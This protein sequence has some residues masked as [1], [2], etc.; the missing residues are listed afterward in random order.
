MEKNEKAAKLKVMESL[1]DDAYKGIARIDSETMR[2]LG[3]RPGDVVIIKGGKETVAIVDRAYPADVGEGIIRIDGII[4]RN[5]KTGIGEPV[6]VYRADIKEAKKVIIAPAQQGIIIQG[7]PEILKRGLL[8]RAVMKGDIIVLGG[9]QRRRDLMEDNFTS[10]FDIFGEAFGGFGAPTFSTAKFIIASTNPNQASIIT[11]S[12]ELVL[13]PKAVEVQE[14]KVPD[15]TYEDIGGLDEELKKIREMVELPLKHPEIFIRLGIEPPKGVLLHGPPGTGKTLLAKAVASETEANFI[16]LNGPECMSKFYGE[17]EKRIRDIFEEAEK[18]APAIIFIDEIDAIAPKREESFGEVERRVV[19]QILTMMDGLKS[20]GK[21]VVIGA[22][23][24]PNS[25]DPALRR[26]GRFDREISINVPDK[27]GRLTILKIHTRNMPLT[28]DVDLEALASITHGFVGADIN[29]LC[30]EAAMNVLRKILPGLKLKE[31]EEIPKEI[32]DKLIVTDKDFREAL[33]VVRPSAMREVLV[34]KPN[35]KWEDVGGLERVK[36]ELREA[37]EWPLKHPDAF[38]RLGI[39]PPTGI[40]LYGAPGTGKTLLAK[41]VANESEANFIQ[42]KGPSLLCLSKDT[43]IISTL[44]GLQNIEKF[45][46]ILKEN[47]IVENKENIEYLTPTKEIFVQALKDKEIDFSKVITAYKLNVKEAYKITFED[48]NTIEVS[49]NQP[50]FTFNNNLEWTKTRDL[51]ENDLIGYP[52]RIKPF[53]KKIEIKVLNNKNLIIQENENFNLTRVFSSHN[54]T[55]LPKFMSEELAEFL[56]WFASEGGISKEKCSVKIFNINPENK[57]RIKELFEMF[58]AKD[59]I[60]EIEKGIA[61]YSAPL[62]Y[63]LEELFDMKFEGRKSHSIKVPKLL[64]LGNQRN[65]AAFLRG[66]W[67]GDGHIDKLKAEYGTKSEKLAQGIS[68]LLTF[69][70]IRHKLWARKDSMFIITISGKEDLIKFDNFVFDKNSE[71]KVRDYYNAVTL[72]P[73]IALLLKKIKEKNKLKYS[74]IKVGEK[75]I[76]EGI[77]EAVL[78]GRKN[79]GIHRLKKIIS[80]LEEKLSEEE[81]K[82]EEFKILKFLIDSELLWIKIRKIEKAEEQVM[83]DIETKDGSFVGGKRPLLL[84]NSMWVGKSLPYTEELIVRENGIIKRIPI[85]EIVEKKDDVEVMAFDKNKRIVFAKIN[86]YIKHK[87]DD[88]LIEITTRTGRKIRVTKY[89]SLFSFMN[90]KFGE[91]SSNHLIA[92]ESYIAV[93]KNLDLPKE[94]IK[95]LNLYEALKEDSEIFV[96]NVG[97]YLIRAKKILGLDRAAEILAVSKKYLADI[98]GK[99]LPVAIDKFD[100]LFNEAKLALNLNEIKIKL[101]GS[102]NEYPCIFSIDKEFWRLV[103]IWIAEGDFNDG[104]RIHNKNEEIRRDIGKICEKFGFKVSET[105]TSMNINSIFLE[106]IFKKVLKLESCSGNKNLPEISF[107]LDKDSKANLLKGYFS[108]DG[109]IYPAE[110]GKYKIEAGTISKRL[111][112]DLMYLLLDFGIVATCYEKQLKAGKIVYRISILGVKNFE[113]F[114]EIGFIENLKNNRIVEYIESR[115][116]FRTDLIPLS[117]ELYELASQNE[118][119]Y[120]KNNSIGKGALKNI[121]LSVDKDRTK[122]KEYWEL[123]EGDIFFDLVKEIKEIDKEEYVYDI[124]VLN[125]Q[126]FIGGFGGVIAHNS[127]EGVRKIFERARQVAPCIIFFDEIDAIAS[128]RGEDAGT[129]VTDRVLNQMLAEMDGLEELENV[130]VIGATNRPDILDTSLLRAGRFDRIVSTEVPTKPGRLEILKIHSKNMPLS[131]DV[132]LTTLAEKTEGY[133]GADLES[134]CR[135]A[136]MLALREDMKAKEVTKKHFEDALKK[137]MPSVTQLDIKKYKEIE[138]NY[139]RAARAGTPPKTNYLG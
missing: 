103:G 63:Y 134:L 17:S 69:A 13:N 132:S 95:S 67:K 65:M 29:S 110:R 31:G 48:G 50:F 38:K 104:V 15:V 7:D 3:V 112:N 54:E 12:T 80:I 78:S 49:G 92:G 105:K 124:E 42:V 106:K 87:L 108:G 98:I 109:S 96:S 123:V 130:V 47:S 25:L 68:Y 97:D 89:H 46:N 26:P 115:K 94:N 79:V 90:G 2:T 102:M 18:T 40:L 74:K 81:K 133:V 19:S 114:I 23:N 84:H 55:K 16:L 137:V 99:N 85:G 11:E 76:P 32:L 62:I 37:V 8:G 6:A 101:R 41:A 127:E 121:L 44:C 33:K 66:A 57:K 88:N 122:Y 1:Q 61:V 58:V 77:F 34:E 43:P 75:Y 111:A 135:E 72:L 116:W 120:S 30:K 9:V 59:R 28:K 136:A 52:N 100:R 64:F 125:G 20:R 71:I 39:K 129:R 113:K 56:G 117:G 131:K 70:G 73:D 21:V 51:K 93:P 24:I 82:L 14:E 60:K 86:D 126:N 119:I 138:T 10:L 5:A 107:I 27:K 128:R 118:W 91:V 36:Q 35:I 4:R 83:Y 53:N 22:T 139:L 45:Y